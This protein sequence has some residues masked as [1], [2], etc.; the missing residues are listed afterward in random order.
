M[1]FDIEGNTSMYARYGQVEGYLHHPD[2]APPPFTRWADHL[3]PLSPYIDLLAS[4]YDSEDAEARVDII[5]AC[6]AVVELES[7]VRLDEALMD[8]PHSALPIPL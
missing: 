6:L 8:S 3:G 1:S 2:P 5:A 4:G 7:G